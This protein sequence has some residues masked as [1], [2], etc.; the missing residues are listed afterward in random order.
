M[1]IGS[2]LVHL[3]LYATLVSLFFAVLVRRHRRE[4]VRMFVWAWGGMVAGALALA[5]V[6][7][8]FPR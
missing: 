5:Y 4:Q 6:M 2:H 1:T 7:Y 3:V 8:P